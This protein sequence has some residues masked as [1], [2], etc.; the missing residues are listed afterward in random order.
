MQTRLMKHENLGVTGFL[1]ESYFLEVVS[2]Y[3]KQT[4]FWEDVKLSGMND[5]Q[6]QMT[7]D[8]FINLYGVQYP[9]NVVFSNVALLFRRSKQT[10]TLSKSKNL[11]NVVETDR[12]MH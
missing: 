1:K 10:F 7:A 8:I 3:E 4:G 12:C 6:V 2:Y 5:V 9:S 11:D